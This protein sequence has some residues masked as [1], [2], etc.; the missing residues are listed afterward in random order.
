MFVTAAVTLLCFINSHIQ[1]LVKG[2][3]KRKYDVLEIQPVR[4]PTPPTHS[5]DRLRR[6]SR[7]VVT[8]CGSIKAAQRKQRFRPF[9]ISSPCVTLAVSGLS[10]RKLSS[11]DKRSR[12]VGNSAEVLPQWIC[13]LCIF[14]DTDQTSLR[15]I[16]DDKRDFKSSK[17]STKPKL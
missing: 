13:S 7:R 14:I 9:L 17:A 8:E 11:A 2:T 10:C 4:N 5:L 12:D 16:F 6:R 3:E 15:H 1:T